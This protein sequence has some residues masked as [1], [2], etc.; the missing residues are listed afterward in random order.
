MVCLAGNISFKALDNA[1][2][3]TLDLLLRHWGVLF[4]SGAF[5]KVPL[6]P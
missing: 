4:F 5:G 1:I 2:R 3:R 6:P